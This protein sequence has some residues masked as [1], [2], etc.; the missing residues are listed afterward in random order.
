VPQRK[1]STSRPARP[2]SSV[3][4]LQRDVEEL[5]IKIRELAATVDELRRDSAIQLRRCGELQHE[6]NELKRTRNRG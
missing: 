6:I 3:V 2:A 1:L 5:A 4:A